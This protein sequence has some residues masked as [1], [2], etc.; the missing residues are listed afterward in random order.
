MLAAI[1]CASGCS[2]LRLVMD[3]VPA[4]DA[5]VE[6]I[7]LKD[8]ATGL[9]APKV[10]LIDVTGLIM[11]A[12]RPGFPQP[13]ENPVAEYV[14]ALRKAEE[15]SRTRA[16]VVR[17]NSPGGTVTASDVLYRE[18]M[19]FKSQSEKP[20]IVLM[21]DLAASG[22]Y[23]LAC[24]GD[25]IIAHPTT[26]TGSVGVIVQLFNFSEGM[27]RIG[28]RA[29][30]ITSG[31]N[32]AAGSP[33]EPFQPEH[34]DIFQGLVDEFFNGFVTVVLRARELSEDALEE[35]LDGR[36]VTGRRAHQLGLVDHVGDL[37]DAF[38]RAKEFAGLE[39]AVLVKYHRP[40]QHVGSAYAQ[41]QPF[42]AAHSQINLL[43]VN[44]AGSAML[45]APAFYYLWDPAAFAD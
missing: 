41:S 45:D 16:V 5:L 23:Y 22:G 4:E 30:S 32:K 36:V 27:R 39:G 28:V 2:R 12:R 18:T 9:A 40:L 17:I 35:V 19:R 3:L 10:V 8:G 13:G 42:A 34:R 43:Q 37:H 25:E 44:M 21:S 11:D 15:D 29:E 20:V 7:V 33:F 6:S 24:A 26:I 1:V 14:E 38:R 31:P